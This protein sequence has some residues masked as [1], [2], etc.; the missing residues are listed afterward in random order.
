MLKNTQKIF[1]ANSELNKADY[2]DAFK[3]SDKE[4]RLISESCEVTRKHPI[5]KVKKI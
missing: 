3:L 2:I 1:Y 4:F 5:K